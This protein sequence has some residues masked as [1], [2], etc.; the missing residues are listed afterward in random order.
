[1][2]DS[3]RAASTSFLSWAAESLANVSLRVATG[4][5]MVTSRWRGPSLG[6]RSGCTCEAGVVA[7]TGAGGAAVCYAF[8][9][10]VPPADDVRARRSRFRA[11]RWF[12]R[13]W[14]LQELIAPRIVVFLSQDWQ[15]I[16][17]KD[18]LADLIQEIT[19]IDRQTLTHEK[20]LAE[21]SVAE[22]MRWA[23]RRSATRVED[24]AY[25]LLGIFGI[26]MPTLYGEGAHAFQRLQAEI[27]QRIPDQSLFAWGDVCQPIPQEPSKIWI[28]S[29]VSDS[30]F[31]S[32]PESFGLSEGKIIPASGHRFE[33]LQLP[34]EEYNPT[35]YGLRTQLC[36]VPLHAV[37]PKLSIGGLDKVDAW[38]LAILGCQDAHDQ[39]RL[40]GRLCYT[41]NGPRS[42]IEFLRIPP[43]EN[44]SWTGRGDS[45]FI[46]TIPLDDLVRAKSST[47]LHTRTVYLPSHEPS[48]PE[49]LAEDITTSAF[50]LSLPT[51]AQVAL[52]LHGYT[53]SDLR[54]TPDHPSHSHSLT[55]SHPSFEIQIH[56]RHMLI[57]DVPHALAIE[58]R[59][60]VLSES[61]DSELDEDDAVQ[62]TPAYTSAIWV[63]V[64]PWAMNFPVRRGR[65]VAP[66]GEEVTLRLGLGLA[67]PSQA[68][69]HIH[70]EIAPS[71]AQATTANLST[72]DVPDPLSPQLDMPRK[73][74]KLT[75]LGSV[76]RALE[77][78]GF[79]VRFEAPRL[80]TGAAPSS[81]SYSLTL[82]DAKSKYTI[83]IKYFYAFDTANI[84]PKP[85]VIVARIALG[86]S[87]N[88]TADDPEMYQDGPYI[89]TWHDIGV[90]SWYLDSQQQTL[91]TPNGDLLTL[92]LGLDLAWQSEYYLLVDVD[93]RC[94]SSL[95]EPDA[96]DDVDE[97][98]YYMLRD[99]HSS[100]TLTLPEHA[101]RALQ[102]QGYDVRF[103]GSYEHLPYSCR[104][105]LSD[106][107]ITIEIQYFHELSTSFDGKQGLT[108]RACVKAGDGQTVVVDWD[109][110]RPESRHSWGIIK[111]SEGWYWDLP[112]KDV[113]LVAPT[114]LELTLRLGFNL[115]WL[116]EYCLTVEVNPSFPS[117]RSESPESLEASSPGAN[118]EE[119]PDAGD[120]ESML[121]TDEVES[122][123][124]G[125]VGPQA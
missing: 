21:E 66:T 48:T 50:R 111:E 105:T 72:R 93:R 59:I 1:M 117:S 39:E 14:T 15:P 22:R 108:F 98:D 110:W 90:P 58:A 18:A 114:G 19:Y 106:A 30:P 95:Q 41:T 80:L 94:G 24:E 115:V 107:N 96:P 92:R 16:G 97:D 29:G 8:L 74:L 27:L 119:D 13:A 31:A 62:N 61:S 99:P 9:S 84:Q 116:G 11:S 33:S 46:F 120:G 113:E 57:G 71:V 124:S 83:S 38:Y 76:R 122:A 104:L 26:T 55:L 75:M 85:I 6:G 28:F 7:S 52:Q 63:A 69:Y 109:A 89:V 35:P 45:D 56:Y 37:A 12:K 25:S 118:G 81:H 121:T 51:W 67:A 60:W 20:V 40:L 3:S 4:I 23:A 86:P 36:L 77:I 54:H 100:V 32:S 68:H 101:R 5:P 112:R 70:V 47:Q 43:R 125:A 78:H 10:D 102:A 44:G 34:A 73:D 65:L 82:F 87:T 64:L 49:R 103:K 91:N 79:S 88:A 2:P 42:G 53:V 123:H 17:T